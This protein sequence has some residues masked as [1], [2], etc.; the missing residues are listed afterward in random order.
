MINHQLNEE[1]LKSLNCSSNGHTSRPSASRQATSVSVASTIPAYTAASLAEVKPW[2]D[3]SHSNGGSTANSTSR[4][5][6]T[7]YDARGHPQ[8]KIRS[9]STTAS[10]DEDDDDDSDNTT[11]AE[12]AHDANAEVCGS[13]IREQIRNANKLGA[14]KCEIRFYED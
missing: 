14:E 8:Q 4:A 12:R 10:D 13:Q 3:L 1:N 11:T 9:P 2:Q 7:G 6:S 5:Y